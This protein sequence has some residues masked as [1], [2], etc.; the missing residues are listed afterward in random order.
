M[1]L[2]SHHCFEL[3]PELSGGQTAHSA[4]LLACWPDFGWMAHDH[5]EVGGK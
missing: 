4:L 5:S 1:Y 3:P 2:P